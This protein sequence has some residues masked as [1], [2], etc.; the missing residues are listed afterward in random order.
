MLARLELA[1]L[2]KHHPATNH[3]KRV[4]E[5]EVL[6][7]CVARNNVLE[8]EAQVRAIPLT[9]AQCVDQLVFGSSLRDVSTMF[10]A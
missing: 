1:G 10:W 9:I 5:L 7:D 6:K 8:Q 2:Q 3:R 4:L